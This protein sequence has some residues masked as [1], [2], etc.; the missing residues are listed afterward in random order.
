[1][2]NGECVGEQ[3]HRFEKI[4]ESESHAAGILENKTRPVERYSR[5]I[6]YVLDSTPSS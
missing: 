5:N 2:Q 3:K 4:V 1:M 6:G